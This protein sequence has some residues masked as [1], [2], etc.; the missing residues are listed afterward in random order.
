MSYKNTM[1]RQVYIFCSMTSWIVLEKL[2]VWKPSSEPG[3]KTWRTLFSQRQLFLL[4]KFMYVNEMNR[5]CKKIVLFTFFLFWFSQ[6]QFINISHV[7]SGF[8][9]EMVLLSVLS[10]IQTSLDPFSKVR[11]CAKSKQASKQ[12]NKH[13]VNQASN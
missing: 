7:W 9:D 1:E 2:K 11:S 6:P 5:N 12:I 8:Q 4:H 3:W 10:N 13:S